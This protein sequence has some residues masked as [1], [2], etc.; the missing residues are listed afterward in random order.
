MSGQAGAQCVPAQDW[1]CGCGQLRA[2]GRVPTTETRLFAS[3]M[4]WE[5]RHTARSRLTRY[6]YER[7]YGFLSRSWVQ[8]MLFGATAVA[9]RVKGDYNA[10]RPSE[11]KSMK[12]LVLL[13]GD[14]VPY[15]GVSARP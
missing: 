7:S 1:H 8:A 6:S 13:S 10:E 12:S 9:T 3:D 14:S 5:R 2:S 15:G 11:C 4:Y